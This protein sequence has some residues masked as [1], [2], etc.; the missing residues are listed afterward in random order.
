MVR[1]LEK[2][3]K[4]KKPYEEKSKERTG[5][6]TEGLQKE[7]DALVPPISVEKER[8]KERREVH[9]VKNAPGMEQPLE[10]EPEREEQAKPVKKKVNSWG[11]VIGE[12]D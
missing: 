1:K 4:T 10:A 9:G 6:M 12:T 5:K 7:L 11:I 2:R 8:P 3:G